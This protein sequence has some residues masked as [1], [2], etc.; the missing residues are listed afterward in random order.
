MKKLALVLLVVLM[1]CGEDTVTAPTPPT[2][3]TVVVNVTQTQGGSGTNPSP[4]PGGGVVS[5]VTVSEFGENCPANS[6]LQPAETINRQVRKGCVSDVTCN[7]FDA[8]GQQIF[9]PAATGTAVFKQLGGAGAGRFTQDSNNSYNG[10][11]AGIETGVAVLECTVMGV[12]S[13]P[14]AIDVV[15]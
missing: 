10:Q 2:N 8:S 13:D 1:G 15:S 6:G 4:A 11:V 12:T 14:W 3:V 7:P 9:N 5:K